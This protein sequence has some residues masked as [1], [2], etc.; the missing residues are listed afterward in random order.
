[1]STAAVRLCVQVGSPARNDEIWCDVLVD[2]AGESIATWGPTRLLRF[3]FRTT[4][5]RCCRRADQRRTHTSRQT[6]PRVP[7]KGAVGIELCPAGAEPGR[8]RSE[9]RFRRLCLQLDSIELLALDGDHSRAGVIRPER[10]VETEAP[11]ADECRAD[12]PG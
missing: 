12:L 2:K 3:R 6:P 9:E 7:C 11:A 4:L 5:T 1:M 8:S 10:L